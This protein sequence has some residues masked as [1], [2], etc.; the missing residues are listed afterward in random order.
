MG[1]SQ[2]GCWWVTGVAHTEHVWKRQKQSACWLQP[3]WKVQC[4]SGRSPTLLR[5]PLTVHQGSGSPLRSFAYDVPWKTSMQ[6]TWSLSLKRWRNNNRSWSSGRPT[7]KERD[8]GSTWAKPRSW[9]LGRG[10][11]CFRSLAKTPV[12]RVSKRRHK[13]HF[14]WWFFQSDPQ[15]MQWHL[16]VWSL[17]L[18]SGVHI[19]WTG[20]TSRWQTNDRGHSGSGEAWVG[21]ILLLPWGLLIHRWQWWTLYYRKMPC[22]MG[23]IQWAPA[24]PHLPL[25]SNHLQRKSLQFVSYECHAP[26][27]R[28]LGP[29]IFRPAWHSHLPPTAPP[30]A[31]PPDLRRL[32][33]MPRHEK[34]W[35]Y[36]TWPA[37]EN[38]NVF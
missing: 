33:R 16:A 35:N 36:V 38:L 25:H 12:V 20:Q 21:A 2:G 1:S 32:Q 19:R 3:E 4:E 27:K 10:S 5:E 29:N 31:P 37:W 22:H 14:L 9:Y 18:A 7:W 6:M 8:F 13:F 30:R 24:R 11:V 26:C 28:N 34:L 17:V 23:Q 15:E